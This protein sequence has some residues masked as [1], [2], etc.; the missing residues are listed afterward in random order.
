MIQKKVLSAIT[1]PKMIK[2]LNYKQ[3]DILAQDVRQEIIDVVSKN[4]GHL[5]PNLGTVDL[6]IALLKCFAP[7]SD[8]I[9]WDVGH[10]CYAYKLLTDRKDSFSSIRL[11]GGI[12][13]FPK[14]AE[15]RY[16]SFV[17][18]HASTSI[19]AAYGIKSA[20][21]VTGKQDHVVAV[22]GDGA[23]TGGLIY[24]AINNAGKSNSNLI[25]ILN[26]NDMSISKS[27]GALARHLAVLR[28]SPRYFKIKNM[29]DLTLSSIP[30]VGKDIREIAS[31]LKSAAKQ[32]IYPNTF[33]EQ[34]GFDYLGPVDGH[35]IKSLCD[36][37][38]QAK[39]SKRPV[40]LH[41]KTTKGKGYLPAEKYSG[42]Y[43]GVST[44]DPQKGIETADEDS[45]SFSA[46]FGME[47][48]RLA[49]KDSSICAITA[50]MES[51]TGL[52][53]FAKRFK[54]QG[55]FFDVGI[56]EGYAVTFASGLA[57]GGCKAV[58][59]VY[60]TFLQ[61][62]YDQ[63]IHDASIEPRNILLAIDR[64]GIVGSDGETH[65]G[66]FDAA[67][68][69]TVPGMTVYAPAAYEEL[70]SQLYS[71]LY[72]HTGPVAIRYPRGAQPM[73][74]TGYTISNAPYEHY[75][76]KGNSRTVVVTYG[77]TFAAAAKVREQLGCGLIKLGRI[78]PIEDGAILAAMGYQNV[79]LVEEGILNGSIS[80]QFATGLC[81]KGYIGR[82]KIRAIENFIPQGSVDTILRQLGLDDSGIASLVN[83]VEQ[84]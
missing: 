31:K 64:A 77:R 29:T 61:R 63:I 62:S 45:D 44:F 15:S 48:T 21:Q 17:S 51:S 41:I 28:S 38:E 1:D 68:L 60:S 7:P 32:M 75:A 37:L 24:E 79:I 72:Q 27:V 50:A 35:S 10:Q 78:T 39:L 42:K 2:S 12:S 84:I 3:L 81:L 40:L 14:T 11:A 69:S 34:F 13:G 33:F 67:F 56:A 6:T 25:V 47:L 74:P 19:A 4:G 52:S 82:V 43:H 70:R 5:S 20:L 54:R 9:V 55:R 36:V 66:I 46:Q 30:V 71:G 53:P 22:V 59:A 8:K 16:D 73:L 18:G 49:E 76:A 23:M 83:E 65:Q 80:M 57:A 58:F 26:D